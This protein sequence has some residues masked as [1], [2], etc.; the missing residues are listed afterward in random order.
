M[1]RTMSAS[2]TSERWQRHG[3]ASAHIKIVGRCFPRE[4]DGAVERCGECRRLHVVR[5]AAKACVAPAEIDRVAFWMAQAAEI[6]HVDVGDSG[7][8]KRCGERFG[9]ELGIAA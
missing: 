8:R 5:I 9:V 2:A 7:R 1:P 3:T 6:F 4:M